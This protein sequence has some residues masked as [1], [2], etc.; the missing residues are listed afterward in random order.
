MNSCTFLE[1]DLLNEYQL[2]TV[3]IELI[4]RVVY[5]N[6]GCLHPVAHM[7]SDDVGFNPSVQR[8]YCSFLL[9]FVYLCMLLA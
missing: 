6:L 5:F 7:R 8:H 4:S 3:F 2:E 1:L 9:V